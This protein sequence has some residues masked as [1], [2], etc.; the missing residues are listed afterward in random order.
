MFTNPLS[1]IINFSC[2]LCCL[3]SCASSERF[4]ESCPSCGKLL[5]GVTI[6]REVDQRSNETVTV[7]TQRACGSCRKRIG[8]C[9][10]CHEPVKGIFVWCPGCGHGG[11]LEHALEW[12]GGGN[13]FC[14]TGCGEFKFLIKKL[15][16]ITLYF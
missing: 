2:N 14:P 9:F 16:K 8:F 5:P 10:I 1:K 15:D 4:H 12:F 6:T 13:Q 7:T 3:K 11:H